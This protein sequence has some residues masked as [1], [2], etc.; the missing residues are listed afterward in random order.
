MNSREGRELEEGKRIYCTSAEEAA[1]GSSGLNCG[2]LGLLTHSW[3][4]TLCAPLCMCTHA[5]LHS[6]D[7]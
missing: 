1:P 2:R 5:D 3:V 7:A 6:Y 4:S